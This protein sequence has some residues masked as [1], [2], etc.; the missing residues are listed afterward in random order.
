M[1][2]P[3]YAAPLAA[4]AEPCCARLDDSG[5]RVARGARNGQWAVVSGQTAARLTACAFWAAAILNPGAA[6]GVAGLANAVS[7]AAL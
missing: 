6:T 7:G 5:V 4:A 1:S 2:L 3:D